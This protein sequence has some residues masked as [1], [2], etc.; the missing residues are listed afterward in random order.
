[1]RL[2]GSILAVAV[3][4]GAALGDEAVTEEAEILVGVEHF[5]GWWEEIPNKWNFTGEDDWRARYPN[6]VPILGEYNTQETMDKEIVAAADH[7]VDFF[8]M[9]WY[10]Q[11]PGKWAEPHSRHLN[12]AV[13]HFQKSPHAHRMKFMFELCNHPPFLVTTDEEWEA[14]RAAM[15]EAMLHPSY[16]RV[17]GR[18]VLK[19]H[20]GGAFVEQQNRDLDQCRRRLQEIR[21]AVEAAGG[22]VPLIGCGVGCAEPIGTEHWAAKLFD[23]TATYMDVPPLEQIGDDYPHEK[24]ASFIRDGR[25]RHKTDAVPYMPFMAANWNPRPWPDP[26]AYFAFPTKEA[27]T[28]E[29]QRMR[30]DLRARPALGLPGADGKTVKA[31]T[32]YAWNEF[33][34]G[35]IVAP[36]RGEGYMK[37]EAIKEVFGGK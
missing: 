19:I 21:D 15:V 6:R 22:G 2:L 12:R 24:L 3:L 32:I 34:E 29:L 37:L 20:G 18:P 9:L 14:C 5:A 27:W 30:D 8:I 10:F 31:F 4:A 16:L 11:H 7:G 13:E 28:R 33:G 1:M 25:A 23:F 17:D 26:R 35:G 36:T